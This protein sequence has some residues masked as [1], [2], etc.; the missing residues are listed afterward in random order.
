M[1]EEDYKNYSSYCQDKNVDLFMEKI[2]KRIQS[3]IFL[4]PNF[5]ENCFSWLIDI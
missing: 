3:I 4:I 1:Y 5:H 2:T